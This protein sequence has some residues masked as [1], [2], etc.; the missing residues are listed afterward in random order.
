MAVTSTVVAACGFHKEM[1]IATDIIGGFQV[2]IF[3][4]VYLAGMY[5]IAVATLGMLSTI[6][7]S[8]AI[9]AYGPI[10][11]EPG[12]IA[13]MAGIS[14]RTCKRTDA[15][16]AAGNTTAT[17]GKGL[18]IGSVTLVSL[19]LF[20]ACVSHTDFCTRKGLTVTVS[21]HGSSNTA[22]EL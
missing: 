13:E 5:G 8:S 18:A 7:A 19:I 21:G 6:A 9:E 20:D 11:D 15:L 22:W 1:Q 16:D 3:V 14:H 10:S 4:N 2:N 17:I 12:G